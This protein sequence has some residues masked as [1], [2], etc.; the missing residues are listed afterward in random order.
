MVI[1]GPIWNQKIHDLAFVQ[2]LLEV[3]Q[4]NDNKSLPADQR[5]V[6]LG[7]S[8]RIQA[9]LTSIIDEDVVAHN[10]LS[11]DVS[12]IASILKTENPPKAKLIAAFR[13]LGYLAAQTYYTPK[14]YTT[15]A[16]PEVLY[17]IFKAYVS[18]R[19]INSLL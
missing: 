1:G 10:P 19:S 18:I 7:T 6:S 4:K 15:N 13:S 12:H 14:L 8:K 2:R 3:V 17:D 5:E 16:P 11:Y 9:I